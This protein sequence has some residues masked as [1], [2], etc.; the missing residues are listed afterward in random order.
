MSYAPLVAPGD[1]SV[2][3]IDM[4]GGMSSWSCAA[5]EYTFDIN[6]AALTVSTNYDRAGKYG[7]PLIGGNPVALS[8]YSVKTAS[9]HYGIIPTWS[10]F[11]EIEFDFTYTCGGSA[12]TQT[13]DWFVST[14]ST[15]QPDTTN[16]PTGSYIQTP[17]TYAEE[18]ADAVCPVHVTWVGPVTEGV[19]YWPWTTTLNSG[20]AITCPNI[21]ATVRRLS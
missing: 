11:A 3:K 12:S 13:R 15:V 7:P 6:G 18:A 10:G 2:V 1:R 9:A 19:L 17:T 20:D 21:V 14:Y 16:A 4:D 5:D 8:Y